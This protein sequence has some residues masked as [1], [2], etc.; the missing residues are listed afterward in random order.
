MLLGNT[1]AAHGAP[2]D[3]YSTAEN[4]SMQFSFVAILCRNRQ[5]AKKG[6]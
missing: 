2:Q 3:R 1:N 5:R 4:E 6:G